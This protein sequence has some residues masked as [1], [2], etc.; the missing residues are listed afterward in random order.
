MRVL[1][2]SEEIT[3]C[4]CCGKRNLK[5]TFGVETDS[6]DVLYYG[7]VCVGK[8]YGKKR[9]SL[10]VER[11][12]LVSRIERLS[13]ERV[14]DLVSRGMLQPAF[15]FCGD[16]FAPDNSTATMARVTE[17][18]LPIAINERRGPFYTVKRKEGA[19]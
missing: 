14:L 16:K 18:K 11:A 10:M 1:G 7:S 9:G 13:W 15:A 19:N 3:V 12:K 5:G 8:V 2:F 17:I 6:G 4:D